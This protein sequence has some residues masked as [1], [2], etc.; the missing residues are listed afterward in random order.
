MSSRDRVIHRVLEKTLRA[1]GYDLVDMLPLPDSSDRIV[2]ARALEEMIQELESADNDGDFHCYVVR[3]RAQ[4]VAGETGAESEAPTEPAPEPKLYHADGTVNASYL[5]HNAEVLISHGE[6][7]LAR[8]VYQTLLQSG[9]KTGQALYGIARCFEKEGKL[10]L[11]LQKY[12]E[13]ASYLPSIEVFLHI[14]G[15]LVQQKKDRYAAEVVERALNIK[16]ISSD[17]KFELHKTAGNC[18]LRINRF[19]ESDRHFFRALDLRPSADE[20]RSNLGSSYLKQRRIPEARNSFQDAVACNPH[21]D[22]AQMG[23]G[24]CLEQAGLKREAHDA[25]AKALEANL[26]NA[27]ALYGLMR[28]AYELKIYAYAEKLTAAFCE[29]QPVSVDILF[30]LAGLQFHLGKIE[31]ARQ[32]VAKV[33]QMKPG[34]TGCQELL[35]RMS[36]Y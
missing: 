21:N 10:D 29:S 1:S 22:K 19:E 17:M 15:I 4:R 2:R 18:W 9:Q 35:Q 26:G 23:Y 14:A 5:D 13:S 20:V 33:E 30:G 34:H 6:Y 12:E 8:N 24:V 16:D 7:A 36:R 11:A 28:L 3:V 27:A 31:E 32:T 25:Y